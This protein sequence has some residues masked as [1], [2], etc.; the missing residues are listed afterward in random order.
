MDIVRVRQLM[1]K[2]HNILMQIFINPTFSNYNN[3][4]IISYNTENG[5]DYFLMDE[6]HVNN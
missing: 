5:N 3:K 6:I 2:E 1:L 4:L